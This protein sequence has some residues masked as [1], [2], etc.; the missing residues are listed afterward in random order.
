MIRWR[1]AVVMAAAL[2]L[3]V[4][5]H[6]ASA[7]SSPSTASTVT[8]AAALT[9]SA[10]ALPP[11][12]SPLTFGSHTFGPERVSASQ[13]IGSMRTAISSWEYVE[14]RRGAWDWTGVDHD[15]AKARARG[16]RELLFVLGRVPAWAAGT[17]TS[18]DRNSP[19]YATPPRDDDDWSTYVS[20]L[21][22]HVKGIIAAN[23][24]TTAAFQVWNEGNLTTFFNGSPERLASLTKRA[25][26][27]IKAQLP[28]APVVAASTTM[29]LPRSYTAFYPRYLKA[30]RAQGWPIDAFSVHTYPPGTGGP[31]DYIGYLRTVKADIAAAGS[32][33]P[34][35][36]TEMNYG[37][38]GPGGAYPHVS[39]TG[40]KAQSW[41]AR[42]YLDA[43]RLGVYRVYWYAQLENEPDLGITM[44]AGTPAMTAS[45]TLYGWLVGHRW[46]GC[47]LSGPV[48]R[49]RTTKGASRFV[50]AWSSGAVRT[51][52]VP[53][54]MHRRCDLNRRC[55]TVKP[56]T[57]VRLTGAVT[58]F[59]A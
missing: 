25:Y 2:S 14:P 36:V 35:W 22:K 31:L 19:V 34:L 23:P 55:V 7:A 42:V 47:S 50:I 15:M 17:N 29:R 56:G 58:R 39:I 6:L 32:R 3:A 24:G 11:T 40:A 33:K 37:L 49:C 53:P 43:M 46:Y 4:P 10:A 28:G 44:W 51:F 1:M 8:A 45:R 5:A 52:V 30:L 16:V 48:V 9:P 59:A 38:R 13:P 41:Y 20:M 12:I 27:A 54:G 21:A 57:R 18:S 26:T